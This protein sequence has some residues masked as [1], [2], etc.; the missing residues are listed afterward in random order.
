[1]TLVSTGLLS[2]AQVNGVPGAELISG[3]R[4]REVEPRLSAAISGAL[5]LPTT[6][7]I[8]PVMVAESLAAKLRGLGGTVSLLTEVSAITVESGRVTGVQVGE[9][10]VAAPLVINAAGVYADVLAATAGSRRYSIHPRRGSL[11]LFDPGAERHPRRRKDQPPCAIICMLSSTY[12]PICVDHPT[13]DDQASIAGVIAST[14]SRKARWLP[15]LAGNSPKTR[16]PWPAS[17]VAQ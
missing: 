6:A 10:H 16:S 1:M 5:Y 3:D 4:A 9:R 11:M 14:R 13:A 2:K 12:R 15:T 7:S 8:D 17:R